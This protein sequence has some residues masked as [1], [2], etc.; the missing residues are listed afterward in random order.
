MGTNTFSLQIIS[1]NR[2]F[3]SGKAKI[4]IFPT[5]DGEFAL[6]ANHEDVTITVEIGEIRF[7]KDDDTWVTGVVSKGFAEMANNRVRMFVYSCEKPDEI[8]I[9]RAQEARERAEERLR[10]KQS[11][12]EYHQSKA[13]LARA[14]ARLKA[15][16]KNHPTGY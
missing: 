10:Q 8:D 11:I 6:M 7:Q 2:T 1:S 16:N 4:I 13:S 5:E 12:I 9:R 15:A 3:Y 14:M